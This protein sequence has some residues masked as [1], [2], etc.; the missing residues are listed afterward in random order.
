MATLV[1]G[2]GNEVTSQMDADLFTMIFGTGRILFDIGRKMQAEIIDN[3]TI[4]VY[5][6]ELISKGR[7]IY[8]APNTYDTF[9]IETGEQGNTRYDIVGYRLYRS[10]GKELCE[11][12]VKK[13]VGITETIEEKSF[14]DGAEEVYISLYKVKIEGLTITEITALYDGVFNG[15][16]RKI[17]C[18]NEEPTG[19]MDGD[20]YIVLSEE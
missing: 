18:G 2:A 11:N 12:F 7:L 19:G 10:D 16:Q 9:K 3:N 6:G 17:N 5:D 8:I 1:N 4:R 14:R 15:L 20:I 13:G